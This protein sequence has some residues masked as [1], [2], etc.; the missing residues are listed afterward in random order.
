MKNREQLEHQWDKWLALHKAHAPMRFD[1]EQRRDLRK[2]FQVMD[3]D[4]GGSIDVS[5][6]ESPPM[7]LSPRFQN[8]HSAWSMGSCRYPR[9]ECSKSPCSKNG[10]R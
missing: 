10:Y 4:S 3:A 1:A 6:L 8:V 2:F 5:E 7:L 9:R